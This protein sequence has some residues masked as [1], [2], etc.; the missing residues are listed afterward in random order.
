M[1]D[2]FNSFCLDLEID[3]SGLDDEVSANQIEDEEDEKD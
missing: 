2:P 3:V 1:P